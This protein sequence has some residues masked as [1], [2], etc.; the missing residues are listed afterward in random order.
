M[1]NP[2]IMH[3]NF[4]EY[5]REGSLGGKSV[6]DVCRIA[7]E[8][9]YDGIEFRSYVPTDMKDVTV[10]E[11][12]ARIGAA[13][14]KYGLSHIL[15]G[16][17]VDNCMPDE[18]A[19]SAEAAEAAASTA[20]LANDLCGTTLCNTQ[21]APVRC[22][23]PTAP[24][25]AHEFHGSAAATQEMW[26]LTVDTYREI[27]KG[28]ETIGVKFAFETHMRYI[29]DLPAA[30]RKLVDLID[31]PM[32]G[33]NMDYGNTVYFP[34]KPSVTETIDI[35]GDK[36]F[37]AH[38]KNSVNMGTRKGCALSDGEI[39]HR[40]YLKKLCDVG[41]AGPIAIEAPRPGDRVW[42]AQQDL[43]YYKAVVASL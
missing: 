42:F 10:E 41:F 36:L 6:D 35:Y 24:A 21:A 8:L 32:I 25:G 26:D 30:S 39:N 3:V 37:Y 28:L 31:S 11:H 12:Y 33:I 17:S 13:K 15:F 18:K 16:I 1:K 38:L 27:G 14:K 2:V 19:V 22:T 7:A 29:H 4:A 43:A 40:E 9:G 20:K 5:P 34:V 23:I